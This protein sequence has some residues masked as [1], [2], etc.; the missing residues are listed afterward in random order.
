MVPVGIGEPAQLPP[1]VTDRKRIVRILL[2]HGTVVHGDLDSVDA[3][4]A[5]YIQEPERE[6]QKEQGQGSQEKP[7]RLSAERNAVEE[8]CCAGRQKDE[9]HEDASGNQENVHAAS[10]LLS[11]CVVIA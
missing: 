1:P 2:I 9:Q 8:P 4:A 7:L 3:D 11:A 6:T 5:V 10:P